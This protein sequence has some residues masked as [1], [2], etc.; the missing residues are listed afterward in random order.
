MKI[1]IITGSSQGI[2]ASAARLCARAGMGVILT[3]NSNPASA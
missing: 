2:G 1:I 3:Y